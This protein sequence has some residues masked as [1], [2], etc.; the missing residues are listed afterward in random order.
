[1]LEKDIAIDYN[2]FVRVVTSASHF[3]RSVPVIKF[4]VKFRIHLNI[5]TINF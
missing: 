4:P 5:C 2:A 1:M 3:N